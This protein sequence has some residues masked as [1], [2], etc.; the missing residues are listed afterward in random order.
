M[1]E[2]LMPVLSWLGNTPQFTLPAAAGILLLL[3]GGALRTRNSRSA[4]HHQY[5]IRQSA[6]VLKKIRSLN[7]W[8]EVIGYLRKVHPSTFE[9]LILTALS[10]GGIRIKRNQRYTGDGGVDGVAYLPSG[11]KLI[12]QA[13]RYGGHVNTQHVQGFAALCDQQSSAGIFVH[14]GK[15]PQAAWG[16]VSSS[17]KIISGKKLVSLL[18]NPAEEIPKIF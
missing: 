12:I 11:K 8:P 5:H 10:D 2:R 4:R 15:T 16:N 13:K 17:V 14:T 18:C 1:F 3:V 9:E 6:S 7:S